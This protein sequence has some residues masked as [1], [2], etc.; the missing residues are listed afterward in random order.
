MIVAQN[1]EEIN[2]PNSVLAVA[3]TAVAMAITAAA[4]TSFTG[5]G[6]TTL[7]LAPI[8]ESRL[9]TFRTGA[10]G[11]VSVADAQTHTVIANLAPHT[12][13]FVPVVLQG[14]AR[15]RMRAGAD[16]DAPLLLVRDANGNAR[17]QDP[18]TSSPIIMLNAFGHDNHDAFLQLIKKERT[19]P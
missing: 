18:E 10:G 5:Y 8:A 1:I 2:V 4:I 13:G 3:G 6:K 7:S 15:E 17:L 19:S 12:F 11:S 16:P 9:L 14:V